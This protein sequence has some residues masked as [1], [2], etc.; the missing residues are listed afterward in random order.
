MVKKDLIEKLVVLNNSVAE[1]QSFKEGWITYRIIG[2]N[3]VVYN[4]ELSGGITDT[5]VDE[6]IEKLLSPQ[7][8]KDAIVFHK[9]NANETE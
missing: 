2:K 7:E 3:K 8:F 1:H 6:F 4:S 5:T 9:S